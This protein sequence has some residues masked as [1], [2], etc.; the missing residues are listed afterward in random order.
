MTFEQAAQAYAAWRQQYD[1][2]AIS[3]EQFQHA[4][5]QIRVTGD[6]GAPWQMD[7][8]TGAWL[9]W[10]GAQW[11]TPGPAAPVTPPP[12]ST[13]GAPALPEKQPW[14]QRIWDIVSIAGSA[15]LAGVWYW[16]T[17]QDKW[18]GPDIRTCI[19]MLVIPICLIAFRKPI[20]RLLHPLTAFKSKLPRMVLL[21]VGLATPVLVSNF[22]YHAGSAEYGYMF[23]TYLFSTLLSYAVLR[24]PAAVPQAHGFRPPGGL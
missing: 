23:R 1:A 17:S 22:F 19:A 16:Y 24:Q 10:D 18:A 9:R 20:D 11:I 7:P 8:A 5:A 14:A 15:A 21:G 3:A 2:G 6:D 12:A 13:P 4:I